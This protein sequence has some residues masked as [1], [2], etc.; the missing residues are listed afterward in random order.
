MGVD[1]SKALVSIA[2][3]GLILFCFDAKK[4]LC[5]AG[6]VK[7]GKHH[8][9]ITITETKPSGHT[10][11]V[12]PDDYGI[13][14]TEDLDIRAE[15]A[16]GNGSPISEYYGNDDFNRPDDSGD[17]EDFRWVI[18]L[19]GN[20]FHKGKL[21]PKLSGLKSRL[22][23]HDGVFYTCKK[24]WEFYG[25]KIIKGRGLGEPATFF[26]KLAH[27]VGIDIVCDKV[28]GRVILESKRS[29]NRLALPR[30]LGCRYEILFENSCEPHDQSHTSDFP[31]FYHAVNDSK[32]LEFDL[33]TA[34]P[35]KHPNNT[36]VR[37]IDTQG[38][39][40]DGDPEVCNQ[41]F[42]SESK[43]LER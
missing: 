19:E 29:R 4:T 40:V 12:L 11:E 42:L 20:D 21:T 37:F 34:V 14:P 26:G 31:L 32:G 18:D 5:E 27:N 35:R 38:F 13:D 25:K 36:K 9:R 43:T 6:M 10:V 22:F 28:D 39:F 2:L 1:H 8:R 7:N 23:I 33:V 16:L 15:N 41:G 30:E 24:T 17:P 3:D